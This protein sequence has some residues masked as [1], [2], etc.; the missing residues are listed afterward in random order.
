MLFQQG[1]GKYNDTNKHKFVK[2]DKGIYL[3]THTSY[4]KSK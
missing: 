4:K 3:T 1:M 2:Q